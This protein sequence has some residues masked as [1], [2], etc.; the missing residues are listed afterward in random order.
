[1]VDYSL[2]RKYDIKTYC[3]KYRPNAKVKVQNTKNKSQSEEKG[4]K[5]SNLKTEKPIG[6]DDKKRKIK[7]NTAS[8]AKKKRKI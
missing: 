3:A 7:D 6:D 8:E 2:S 1:M 4:K 5:D